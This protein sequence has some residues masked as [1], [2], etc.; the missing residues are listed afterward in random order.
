M[1]EKSGYVKK[2]EKKKQQPTREPDHLRLHIAGFSKS[3][4]EADVKK[5]FAGF[6]EFTMPIKR[7]S[8]L[9]MGFAFAIFAN[10]A[11]AKKALEKAN[12][13]ELNGKKLAVDFAFKRVD[14]EALVKK[15]KEEANAAKKKAAEAVQ[16]AAKKQKAENGQA[17]VAATPKKE[18]AKAAAPAAPKKEEKDKAAPAQSNKRKAEVFRNLNFYINK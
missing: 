18:V 7:D 8:Q 2:D 6:T 10:E 9:N 11:D 14:K 3:T 4:T 12:G 13:K 17:A 5:L 16:P 15:K 1:G